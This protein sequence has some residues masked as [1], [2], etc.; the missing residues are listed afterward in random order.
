MPEIH[1]A[2]T[3]YLEVPAKATEKSTRP[4]S[5]NF[6]YPWNSSRTEIQTMEQNS[7]L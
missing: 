5:F 4:I 3:Q 2:V 6:A 1:S 7:T